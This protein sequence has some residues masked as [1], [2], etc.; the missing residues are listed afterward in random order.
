MIFLAYTQPANTAY[1]ILLRAS[2][3]DSGVA[4]IIK[5]PQ[6]MRLIE[7]QSHLHGVTKL[8]HNLGTVNCLLSLSLPLP[9]PTLSLSLFY[10]KEKENNSPGFK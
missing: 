8:Q 6:S 4:I 3:P 1:P 5:K 7:E 2:S 9:S 10:R